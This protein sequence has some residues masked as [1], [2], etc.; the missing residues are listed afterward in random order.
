M[1]AVGAQRVRIVVVGPQPQSCTDAVQAQRNFHVKVVLHSIEGKRVH[2]TDAST[3]PGGHAASHVEVVSE[4]VSSKVTCR[5]NK[6]CTGGRRRS[7][8]GK[9]GCA[10]SVGVLCER[11]DSAS[12]VKAPFEGTSQRTPPPPQQKPRHPFRHLHT[13]AANKKYKS[14]TNAPVTHSISNATPSNAG[15]ARAS[16]NS[17]KSLQWTRVNS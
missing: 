17:R 4:R 16:G 7:L 2:L 13:L 6:S 9:V 15:K 8:A 1:E 3:S 5:G 11:I 10:V 14:A 12:H